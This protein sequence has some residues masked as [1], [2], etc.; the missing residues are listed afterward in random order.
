[1]L[2]VTEAGGRV[3][4][5]EGGDDILATGSICAANPDLHPLLLQ[6][7]KAAS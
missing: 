7:L 1:M 3:T 6:R 2:I 5:A 4:D